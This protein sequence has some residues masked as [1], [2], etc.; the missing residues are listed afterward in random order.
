M[1][2]LKK[3][4]MI[5]ITIF[6]IMIFFVSCDVT[7]SDPISYEEIGIYEYDISNMSQ[8]EIKKI[9]ENV[10]IPFIRYFN[11]SKKIIYGSANSLVIINETGKEEIIDLDTLWIDED[12]FS[13]SPNNRY[14][15]FS[16]TIIPHSING[17]IEYKDNGLYL[18]DLELKS[19]KLL[20]NDSIKGIQFPVF[21][22]SGEK[23]LF[24]TRAYNYAP[25]ALCV[26]DLNGNNLKKIAFHD[27]DVLMYGCFSVDD[28]NV[29]FI[30]WPDKLKLYNFESNLTTTLIENLV[31]IDGLKIREYPLINIDDHYL[32]YYA[33]ETNSQCSQ[34]H[35]YKMDFATKQTQLLN[36]GMAPMSFAGDY[37][38]IRNAQCSEFEP[39]N[40]KLINNQGTLMRTLSI[41]YRGAISYDNL[42][43][44][45]IYSKKHP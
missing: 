11:G 16:G 28:K 14:L 45:Y 34:S 2:K 26:C 23:L 19:A 10:L 1:R 18:Y 37:L 4:I 17:G 20:T 29:I 8:R 25:S 44:V 6:L 31:L 27:W 9:G 41:G 43:I 5:N 13:I 33:K 32:Y 35:I 40:L 36:S 3:T 42:K 7:V 24:K 38:L 21:S 30:D 39:S 12:F 22:N 15:A